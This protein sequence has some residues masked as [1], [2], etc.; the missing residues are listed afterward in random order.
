MNLRGSGGR[1]YGSTVII[2]RIAVRDHMVD[3]SEVT[4]RAQKYL[5]ERPQS[6]VG[7]LIGRVFPRKYFW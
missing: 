4:R 3:T 2:C 1:V 6:D 5:K 7:N